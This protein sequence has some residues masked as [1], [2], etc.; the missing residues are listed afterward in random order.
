MLG[1]LILYSFFAL[2]RLG[3]A[4]LEND[5]GR[6]GNVA[7]N[8]LSDHHQLAT[9]SEDPLGGP[10]TKPF[11]YGVVLAGAISLFGKSAF[12]LRL[13]SGVA[14]LGAGVILF[15]T[16]NLCFEDQWLALLTFAFFLL[17]PWTITYAHSTLPETVLV[18]WGLLALYAC[19]RFTKNL[20]LRWAIIC[21]LALGLSFL[22]KLWLCFPFALA[23]GITFAAKVVAGFRRQALTGALVASVAFLV[24]ASSHLLLVLWWTPAEM[25]YWLRTYFNYTASTRSTGIGFDPVLWF[26]PWW[27]YSAFLFK[28]TFFGFPALLTASFVLAQKRQRIVSTVLLAILSPI[29]IL[30]FFTVKQTS[31]VFPTFP[32]AAFLV[33][34]GFLELARNGA[35]RLSIA[36]PATVVSAAIAF[37][38][39]NKGVVSSVEFSAIL[40]LYVLYISA[41][42]LSG[43]HGRIVGMI[44]GAGAAGAM[45]FA[46]TIVVRASLLHRTYS[47]E[48]AAYFRP[49]LAG[50]QPQAVVFQAPEY[51]GVEFLLFRSGRSWQT[52]YLHQESAVF[53]RNLRHAALAFYV[54]DPTRTL[55]GGHASAEEVKSLNEYALDVTPT[56]EKAIGHKISLEVFV[57]RTQLSRKLP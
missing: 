54:V 34:Y 15:G 12:T 53:I 57:P 49:A 26:H 39:Y 2:Y 4:D 23:C 33:A 27:F 50:D 52:Y 48:V 43:I 42:V 25:A 37:F 17:D 32:A 11:M 55:Y 20:S 13:L 44:V 21:G 45:L 8:I 18:L 51:A 1:I 24:C 29:L 14:L 56:I 5:E 9:L 16:V 40:V 3:W 35:H 19:V 46:T 38:I 10:G 6:Y 30:S 36:V 47:R 31:Y 28:A 41:A 7:L 22:T